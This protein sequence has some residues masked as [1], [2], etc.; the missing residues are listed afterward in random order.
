LK[1]HPD[2]T[3][4]LT[5]AKGSMEVRIAKAVREL[6]IESN[7]RRLGY[8]PSQDLDA[9]YDEAIA[10]TFPSRFE[11]FGAPVLEAMARGCP[12]I[13]ADATA[14]PE[15]VGDSGCLVSPDNADHWHQ[16][17]L[18]LSEGEEDAQRY[19]KAGL[20]RAGEFTWARSADILEEAYLHALG[21][22]L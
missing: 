20:A 15:V 11:G 2:I 21:T 18:E 16:A 4:V 19:A 13:A 22:T 6:G 10:L 3:L 7:V 17:M 1:V 14:L 9:L 8:I 12:V 5:G